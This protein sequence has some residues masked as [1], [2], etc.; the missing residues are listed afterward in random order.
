MASDQDR[1][2]DP[3]RTLCLAVV[4]F[5]DFPQLKRLDDG[6]RKVANAAAAVAQL[7]KL[8]AAH[9]GADKEREE[10]EQRREADAARSARSSVVQRKLAEIRKAFSDAVSVNEQRRGVPA[11]AVPV[12]P[13]HAR[14][15]VRLVTHASRPR[16]AARC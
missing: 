14:R 4:A 16:A 3:L 5:E 10:I 1:Y 11:R 12:D 6:D 8:A 9:I 2:L 7:R 15:G 13:S